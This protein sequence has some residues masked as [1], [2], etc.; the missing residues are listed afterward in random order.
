MARER[1]KAQLINARDCFYVPDAFE[2]SV[3]LLLRP[4]SKVVDGSRSRL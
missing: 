4:V 3:F 1:D 2:A